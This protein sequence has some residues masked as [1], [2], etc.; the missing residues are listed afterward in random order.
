MGAPCK[1]CEQLYRTIIH[2]SQNIL[3]ITNM[4]DSTYYVPSQ[5]VYMICIIYYM[6]DIIG[7]TLHTIRF[8]LDIAR[9]IS[10]TMRFENYIS[11]TVYY[12]LYFYYAL[13]IMSEYTCYGIYYIGSIHVSILHTRSW[14][15]G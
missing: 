7:Y 3:H 2:R 8:L 14:A 13:H 9:Y 6:G 11:Y 4:L 1:S 5:K 10:H 15:Q 12:I